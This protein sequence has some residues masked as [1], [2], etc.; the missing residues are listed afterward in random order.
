MIQLDK[1][2]SSILAFLFDKLPIS[3]AVDTLDFALSG[4]FHGKYYAAHAPLSQGEGINVVFTLPKYT[5]HTFFALT[6]SKELDVAR[7]LANIEDCERVSSISLGFGEAVVMQGKMVS[8]ES[9]EPY[10]VLLLRTA[11]AVDLRNVPDKE[12]I[13]GQE[14][15]FLLAVPL[16]KTEWDYRKQFGHDALMDLFQSKGKELFFC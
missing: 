16:T 7:L 3:D 6:R 5:T 13:N 10:G 14:I 12:S 2:Q 8:S 9:W 1:M 11:S 15:F 4:D